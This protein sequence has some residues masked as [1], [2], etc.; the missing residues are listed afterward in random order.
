MSL[1]VIYYFF[2]TLLVYLIEERRI[3]LL[4][5]LGAGK[6]HT[7][8]GILGRTVFTSTQSFNTVT[9]QCKFGFS[10]RN[11]VTFKVFDTP[12]MDSPDDLRRRKVQD[13]IARCLFCTSPGFHAIVLVIAGTERISS[14]N[15]KMLEKLN[16]LLGKSAYQYMIIVVSR[17]SKDDNILNRMISESPE[18]AELKFKCRNRV[19]SFGDDSTNIPA[20]CVRRFD[21]ILTMM[22]NENAHNGNEYYTHELY[23]KAT[24]ILEKDINDYI[25]QHQNVSEE[26]ASE[27]VRI[28]AAEGFSPRDGDLRALA[29][30]GCCIIL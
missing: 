9:T 10:V 17:V 3:V 2:K 19:L 24:R 18:M 16:D 25:R 26:E 22:I 5:K 6:S 29:S 15:F 23:Q 21:D 12:G 30:D 14:E 11:A 1:I 27:K 28:A 4:G 7:G 8:N 20:D 13:D